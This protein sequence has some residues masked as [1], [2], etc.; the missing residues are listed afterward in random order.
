MQATRTGDDGLAGGPTGDVPWPVDA[1]LFASGTDALA[2]LLRWG[3]EHRGW[4]RVWLPSYYCPEVPAALRVSHVGVV[5]LA[6]PDHDLRAEPD[7]RGVAVAE[8]DV[9]VVANQLGVRAQPERDH[10]AR[11]GIVLV[12]DHSHDLGSDWALG[13]AADYAFASLRKTLPIPD[14]GVVWSPRGL[15][16]PPEPLSAGGGAAAHRLASAIERR[17]RA[18]RGVADERLRLR[19]LARIAAAAAGK[20]A[21][22]V[23]AAPPG[24]RGRAGISP[25]SRALLAQM[26]VQ[27]WRGRRRANLEILTAAIGAPGGARIL[28]SPRGGVAFALTLLF[29]T[30]GARTHAQGAL[31]ARAVAPTVL[32][33]LDPARDPGTSRADA[34]LSRRIL[35]VHADQ[36]FDEADMLVLAAILREALR[37]A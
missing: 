3:A 1:P 2:A 30:A 36:R 29:D 22:A 16:L 6:Y 5:V 9:V 32:W 7:T 33:P 17:G 19:A 37:S 13:S 14:G 11:P 18:A 27:A 21:E 10:V 34:D 12:E 26:P 28:A 23:A 4:S 35:S 15:D 24:S 25:V 20:D 31:T 8:G